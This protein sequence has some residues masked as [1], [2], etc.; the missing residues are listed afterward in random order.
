MAAVGRTV[1]SVAVPFVGVTLTPEVEAVATVVVK[2]LLRWRWYC[3]GEMKR[4]VLVLLVVVVVVV[5]G[6]AG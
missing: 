4:T 5:E 6:V 2:G 1:R 3:P